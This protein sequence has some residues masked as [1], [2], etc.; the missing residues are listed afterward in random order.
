MSEIDRVFARFQHGRSPSADRREVRTVPGRGTRGNRVVEVVHR[1]SGSPAASGAPARQAGAS[2]RAA[3]WDEGFPARQAPQPPP[4]E[5]PPTVAAVEPTIHVMPA[6]EPATPVAAEAPMP[7]PAAPPARR[8][9]A[10][11]P[12]ADPFDA[13]DEGANCLRC[14]YLV[15]PARERRGLMTCAACG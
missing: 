13:A 12:V 10:S 1:R 3:T 8:A 11:R 15:E 4:P 7:P 2:L 6:W 14:G 9:T 5:P